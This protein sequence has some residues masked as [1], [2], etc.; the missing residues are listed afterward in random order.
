M[1]LQVRRVAGLGRRRRLTGCGAAACLVAAVV[2]GCSITINNPPVDPSGTPSP[3]AAESTPASEPAPEPA[4]ET[5]WPDVIESV[6]SGVVL[7][8]STACLGAGTGSG[9][10]VAPDLVL[11][12]AHVVDGSQ[13]VTIQAAEGARTGEVMGIDT[14]GDLA[15]VRVDRALRGHV[16]ELSAGAP[17]QGEEILGLGYP[18]GTRNLVTTDGRI[19]GIDQPV[20]TETVRRADMIQ[21]DAGLNPGNSGGPVV[22]HDGTVVGIVSAGIAEANVTNFA[23]PA[24][25][26]AAH[27]ETW[28]EATSPIDFAPCDVDDPMIP[29]SFVSIATSDP[30]AMEVADLI[31]IHGR[32]INARDFA[33]AYADF[34]PKMQEYLGDPD[35]WASRFGDV[36]WVGARVIAVETRSDGAYLAD[37]ELA[38][39]GDPRVDGE[40]FVWTK[41]YVI[42]EAGGLKIGWVEDRADPYPCDGW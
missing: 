1:S 30:G 39:I 37:V 24:S 25:A 7:I 31:D 15:L 18:F 26:A 29:T 2:A 9:F 27:V 6:R 17:R 40:C 16:F 20:M 28:R 8:E 41:H 19:S 33:A 32:A 42:K 22:L 4:P 38:R 23:V 5:D 35:D 13:D 34:T 3:V 14:A 12:A 36:Q 11:T 21:T 10:L